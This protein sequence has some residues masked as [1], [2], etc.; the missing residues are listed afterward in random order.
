[1]G[2][3][4]Y[5]AQARPAEIDDRLL[6]HLEIV[7][8]SKLRRQETFALSWI[9]DTAGSEGGSK[10]TIWISANTDLEFEYSTTEHQSINRAWVELLAS[11][12]DRGN[13]RLRPEPGVPD[14]LD[15]LLDTREFASSN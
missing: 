11:G 12:A 4:L 6:A 2:N 9:G 15:S 10:R 1:M 14:S 8:L 7:I 13:L 5:G 3:L